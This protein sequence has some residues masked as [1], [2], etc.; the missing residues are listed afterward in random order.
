MVSH[1]DDWDEKEVLE[2]LIA[3]AFNNAK[4][5]SEEDSS[6][7]LKDVTGGMQ[8]PPGLKI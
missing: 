3:V 7:F 8:L 4:K 5:K 2:D 6:D 1:K